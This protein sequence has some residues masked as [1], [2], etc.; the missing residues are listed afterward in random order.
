MGGGEV[1]E[2]REILLKNNIPTY[3]TPEEAV[4][5]Y[6]YMYRYERNLELLYETPSE[7]PVDQAPAK[8]NLKAK[9]AAPKPIKTT[10]MPC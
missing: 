7:L 2:G 3:D 10:W 1:R 4:R 9:A 6:L 8:N 5:T